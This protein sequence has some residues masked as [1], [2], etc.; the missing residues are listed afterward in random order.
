MH[1]EDDN[2]DDNEDEN[3]E[4]E[5]DEERDKANGTGFMEG[6]KRLWH[7]YRQQN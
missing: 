1:Y 7:R 4:D 6:L 2:E 3:D 5:N